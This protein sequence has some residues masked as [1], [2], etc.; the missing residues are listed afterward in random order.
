M[1]KSLPNRKHPRLKTYDYGSIGAY[2]VTICAENRACL[3]SEIRPNDKIGYAKN[4]VRS[5]VFV[6]LT[7]YGKIAENVLLRLE[8]IY[9]NV[10]VDSY[11]IMPNHIHA[12]INISEEEISRSYDNRHPKSTITLP[13]IICTYKSL[14][15]K[16]CNKIKRYGKIFQTSFYEHIIRDKN[17]YNEIA[18]YIFNNPENWHFDELFEERSI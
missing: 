7:E 3:F 4:D 11:V 5:S 17:D 6:E 8:K 10:N 2:F 1:E 18:E 13:S 9:P 16:E 12:I 14:T 15:T